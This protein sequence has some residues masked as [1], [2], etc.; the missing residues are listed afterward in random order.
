MKLNF[1]KK[2]ISNNIDQISNT[3]DGSPLVESLN[4]SNE[5]QS[6]IKK[7]LSKGEIKKALNI[8]AQ[9][10]DQIVFQL[11]KIKLEQLERDYAFGTITQDD[12]SVERSKITLQILRLIK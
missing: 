11:L 8:L 1:L 6:N 5:A 3:I 4:L 9:E 2:K 12:Y 10:S 7:I